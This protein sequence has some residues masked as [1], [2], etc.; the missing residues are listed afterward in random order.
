MKEAPRIVT[1]RLILR[2]HR[3]DDFEACAAMWSDSAVVRYIGGVPSTRQATWFR[4]LRYAGHWTLLGFGY[5]AIE[6][7]ASGTFLGEVGYADFKRD[8]DPP[9]AGIPELGW[10]LASSAH[11]KGFGTEAVRA[12]AAWGDEHLKSRRTV[13]IISP[14][15][16]PSFRVANKAGFKEYARSTLGGEAAVLFERFAP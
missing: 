12:A 14:E 16:A 10:V 4:L 3:L 1:E 8:L 15:N 9:I 13:C 5:W 11:G 7:L 2:A 6:D